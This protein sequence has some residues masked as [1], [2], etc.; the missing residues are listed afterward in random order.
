MK[1]ILFFLAAVCLSSAANSK[2]LVAYYS[3]TGNCEAIVTELRNQITADVVE[4]EPAEKGL[5]Y[6]ANGYA[7]GT[8]LLN[9]IADNPTKN[10]PRMKSYLRQDANVEGQR[11]IIMA[12]ATEP[13]SKLI[14][15]IAEIEVHKK[16]LTEYLAAA[17]RV[18]ATSV[19]QEP[20]VVCI[21]PMQ[22]EDKANTIRIVEI[23][24]DSAAYQAHL[25]TPHFLEYKQ[26]TLH[27]VK[28]LRLIDTTPLDKDA[29]PL[30]FKKY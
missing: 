23:Y 3:Y 15:R 14:T 9:A 26:S 16:Y 4:I 29:M 19:A 18:G 12:S 21:F 5:R 7:L 20:G 24:R 30:I 11:D 8:Q 25:Q 17:G 6:E 27:M 13:Q 22:V 28:S 10:T 1:R 2:T